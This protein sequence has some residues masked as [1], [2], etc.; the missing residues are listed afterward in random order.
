MKISK[1]IINKIYDHGRKEAPIE[2]C[3]YLAG[4]NNEVVNYYPMHNIDQ[5]NEHFTFDPQ[6][7]FD[8][9]KKVRTEQLEILAVYHTHP[10]SPA[11]P[12]AE[13]IRLAFDPG[14]VYVI[15][16]LLEDKKNIKAY[17]IIKG[18]VTE[19]KLIILG[20]IND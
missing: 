1:K 14:I 17:K 19:K 5:S 18:Q 6:E 3:G 2:A 7:Q 10:E 20:A 8:V 11:R 13:D 15:L 4:I 16:S 12:S 9:M